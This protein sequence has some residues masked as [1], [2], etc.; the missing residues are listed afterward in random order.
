MK[1]IAILLA[2]LTLS[3]H[4]VARIER[5]FIGPNEVSQSEFET[6]DSNG[7]VRLCETGAFFLT[8]S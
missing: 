6:V 8:A 2:I 7:V 4:A 3:F 1:K 5:Y